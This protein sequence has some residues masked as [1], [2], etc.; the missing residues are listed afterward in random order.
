MENITFEYMYY[1]TDAIPKQCLK[2]GLEIQK[3]HSNN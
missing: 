3:Q 2:I 1:C